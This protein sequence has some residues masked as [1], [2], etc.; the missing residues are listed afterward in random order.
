MG[1]ERFVR[2]EE[3]IKVLTTIISKTELAAVISIEFMGGLQGDMNWLKDKLEFYEALHNAG[4]YR[5]LAAAAKERLDEYV[6][7]Y[8]KIREGEE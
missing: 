4:A 5:R 7:K 8:N 6:D 2:F 1:D 3:K